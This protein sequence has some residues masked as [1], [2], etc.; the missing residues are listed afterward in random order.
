MKLKSYISLGIASAAVL[1]GAN[2]ASAAALQGRVGLNPPSPVGGEET[3]VILIGT[4]ETVPGSD[5]PATDFDWVPPEGGGTGA[6]IEINSNPLPPQDDFA[7]F[8]GETGTIQDITAEEIFAVAAGDTIDDFIVIPGAFSVNVTSVG[9]PDYTFDGSGT[10]I[11][12]GVNG[13]FI[14]LS[15]GSGDVSQGVGTFSVDFAGLTIAET[16]ELFDEP[17]EVP[18]Q[19]NP[20]TYSSNWVVT[21]DVVV[22]EASNLLGLLVIGL[23][24][25]SMLARKKK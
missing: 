22:P 8:V 7:D 13:D 4:G 25:A 15:D 6:I 11:S 24:G 2:A 20:G 9:I 10:T 21:D 16:Q 5:V 18:V 3:G 1:G 23:G 17:G 12:L 19:F 14:N